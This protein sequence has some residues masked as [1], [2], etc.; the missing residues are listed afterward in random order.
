M[1]NLF[2]FECFGVDEVVHNTGIVDWRAF[3]FIGSVIHLFVDPKHLE[4]GKSEWYIGVA[5]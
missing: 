2:E 4:E 3:K 1:L 5:L